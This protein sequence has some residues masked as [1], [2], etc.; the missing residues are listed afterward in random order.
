MKSFLDSKWLL[1]LWCVIVVQFIYIAVS[2]NKQ[3]VDYFVLENRWQHSQYN[4]NQGFEFKGNMWDE[5][6]YVYVSQA[7][8]RG[9]DPSTLNFEHPPLGKYLIGW[10]YLLTRQIMV[11]QWT[12]VVVMLIVTYKIGESLGLSKEMSALATS[13]LSFDPLL[14]QLGTKVNLDVIHTALLLTCLWWLLK[15]IQFKK[16]S[17]KQRYVNELILGVLLAASLGSKAVFNG[18]LLSLFVGVVI[19]GLDRS[20]STKEKVFCLIRIYVVTLL[21]YGLI[22][23]RFLMLNGLLDFG[24][25]HIT[26]LRFFR[27]YLPEY[28]WFEIWRILMV[29]KWKT[30]F[31][32]PLIQPVTEF[33][34]LWPVSLGLSVVGLLKRVK[35]K[36]RQFLKSEKPLI[37]VAGWVGVYMIYSSIHVVFPRYLLPVLPCLYLMAAKIIQDYIEFRDS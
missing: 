2:A 24:V 4:L 31:T 37:M 3:E 6:L 8:V 33:W 16:Q 32:D 34:W 35:L 14:Y 5:D 30:W 20:R 17:N 10:G 27:S 11:S 1:F 15:Y 25:L 13:V 21:G 22:Y 19:L 29:G 28:P 23:G 9:V 36:G 12:A 26:M 7:Y 18:L